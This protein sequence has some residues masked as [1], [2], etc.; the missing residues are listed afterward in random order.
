VELGDHGERDIQ[1]HARV[2]D[3]RSPWV[4]VVLADGAMEQHMEITGV[5][6]NKMPKSP[7]KRLGD[8]GAIAPKAGAAAQ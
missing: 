1:W 7:A 3:T 5:A 4:A 6:A 8:S 2:V